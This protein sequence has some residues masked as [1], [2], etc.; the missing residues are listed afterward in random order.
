MDWLGFDTIENAFNG[1]IKS[2]D[3]QVVAVVKVAKIIGL[4]MLYLKWGGA[5]FKANVQADIGQI[6]FIRFAYPIFVSL[7]LTNYTTIFSGVS[8]AM[9]YTYEQLNGTDNS[10]TIFQAYADAGTK[11]DSL[12]KQSALTQ[13]T[14]DAAKEAEDFEA[15]MSKNTSS[16]PSTQ[17]VNQ[18]SAEKHGTFYYFIHPQEAI[19]AVTQKIMT[20]IVTEFGKLSTFIIKI[21]VTFRLKLLYLIGPFAIA[22]SMIPAYE[23]SLANFVRRVIVFSMWLPLSAVVNSLLVAVIN[24]YTNGMFNIENTPINPLGFLLL[25]LIVQ[26]FLYFEIPKVAEDII[27]IGQTGGNNKFVSAVGKTAGT[28]IKVGAS[29]I[30]GV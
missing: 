30:A 23:N 8:N 7:L 26:I 14:G 19:V 5:L 11:L 20:F 4:S 25:L 16:Q 15:E 10:K 28:V 1:G 21:V 22:F 9:D 3:T 13:T 2:L 12:E 17:Q 18:A 24:S 27:M 6:G 29:A